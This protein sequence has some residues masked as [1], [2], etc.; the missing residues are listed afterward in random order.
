MQATSTAALVGQPTTVTLE[1]PQNGIKGLKH[2]RHDILAGL[3]VSLISLPF[4]L[5]IAVASGAPPITGIIS[6]IIAGF[7]LPFLGGSYVTVS[8]PAAG[9]API[10]LASMMV[11]GHGD[12]AKGY[13]LLLVAICF[14][15][16]VQLVLAR[17]KFARLCAMFPAAVVEGML[18][19]IGLLI[20]VKQFPALMGV[21]FHAHEFYQYVTEVPSHIAEMKPTVFLIG[22][23]SLAL[24]FA[25][26]A[27]KAKWLKVVPPQVIAVVV[28]SGLGLLFGLKGDALINIPPNPLSGIHL[29]HFQEVWSDMSL[30]PAIV[31]TVVTLTLIDGIESLAT[32]MAIDKIDPFHRK[33]NPDRTLSAMGISN[34]V[35]SLA[36]G[37]TI[38][39]G[40]VKSTACIMSGGRTQWANFYNAC[41]L[42]VYLLLARPIIN[43][44]PY[45]VL[46][47]M[48]IFTGYKLCRPKVWKHVAHIGWEQLAVFTITVVATLSTDLLWGIV[49][50]I[51]A[52]LAFT[53]WV[54]STTPQPAVLAGAN[55]HAA[56]SRGWLSR[57]TQ[58][59][60][61]PVAHSES[62]DDEH[63][64]YFGGPLVS[65][66]LMHVTHELS[67]AA[68][69]KK[70]YLHVTD[71]VTV[72]DHTSC[73]SLMHFA[74]EC[75]RSGTAQV[76]L[77]GLDA[78]TPRSDFP[79]CMRTRSAHRRGASR[80][81]TTD[82]LLTTVVGRETSSAASEGI[83]TCSASTGAAAT[84]G[85]DAMTWLSLST[86]AA[87]AGGCV[88][89]SCDRDAA[90]RARAEMDWIDLK[91]ANGDSPVPQS[92]KAEAR[93]DMDWLSLRSA[94]GGP[95]NALNAW[96][97]R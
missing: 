41:F 28:G 53:L 55:G 91:V 62:I 61:S 82:D 39:P 65:F 78:M 19:S 1:K 51:V 97:P 24:M 21:K 54:H 83:V 63:H 9:L 23:A 64:V 5:G 92:R 26:S 45:G 86:P 93:R 52:K 85:D 2:F 87:S 17:F 34:L 70:I 90:E 77:L 58:A 12:T 42:L 18:C 20:I 73:E 44:M 14:A 30:W 47:A 89:E 7:V 38:I 10:L 25:L 40:G 56:A 8:G 66:N 60:R 75:H 46:A 67:Q 6:A 68:K 32:V 72:V 35:S 31:T 37:L 49:T 22:I 15:G 94:I 59:F 88:N 71:Q 74:E 36:G 80:R 3:V 81:H 79:S 96:F 4:S 43:L 50:G 76:E 11:L 57:L 16:C 13:P 95:L 48:L 69:A 27:G 29:P 33:S 84:D